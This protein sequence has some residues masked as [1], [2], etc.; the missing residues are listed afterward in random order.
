MRATEITSALETLAADLTA[1]EVPATTDPTKIEV[2]GAWVTVDT[3][4]PELMC[5]EFTATTAIYL[6]ARDNGHSAAL[7][8]LAEMLDRIAAIVPSITAAQPDSVS[9]PGYSGPLPALRT[10]A[11]IGD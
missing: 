6:I 9:L 7:A 11:T 8:D 3:L 4:T 10:T 2:P 1:A 5:G